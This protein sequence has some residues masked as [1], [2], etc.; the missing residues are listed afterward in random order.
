MALAGRLL[1]VPATIVMPADAPADRRFA[2]FTLDASTRF[3]TF[4][5]QEL[6][7]AARHVKRLEQIDPDLTVLIERENASRKV[8]GP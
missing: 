4:R 1:G 5:S 7:L 8:T 6:E 3:P 2:Q